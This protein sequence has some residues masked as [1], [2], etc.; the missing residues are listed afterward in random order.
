[1][2]GLNLIGFTPKVS[3]TSHL[4]TMIADFWDVEP[5]NLI[6]VYECFGG[7]CCR[8]H[9]GETAVN[10]HRIVGFQVLAAANMK[11]AVV[12]WVV[13]PCSLVEVYRRFRGVCCLPSSG[14]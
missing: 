13:A 8:H 4:K 9:Q 12:V 6:E 11:M 5:C 10:L 14:Q 7:V 2:P 3:E 1:M